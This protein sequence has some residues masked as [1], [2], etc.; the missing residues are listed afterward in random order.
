MASCVQRAVGSE[1]A[2]MLHS[3]CMHDVEGGFVLVDLVVAPA[4]AK[5]GEPTA[6]RQGKQAYST[7]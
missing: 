7:P 2:A 5:V 6:G 1:M 4:P 3:L